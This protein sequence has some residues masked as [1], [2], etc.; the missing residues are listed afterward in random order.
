MKAGKFFFC[1]I[2]LLLAGAVFGQKKSLQEYLSNLPFPMPKTELPKFNNQYYYLT[3]FGGKNDGVSLNTEAFKKAIEACNQHGGGHVVVTNGVWLTGP[4][5]IKSNVDLHV[6]KGAIIL[7][8]RDH[9]QYPMINAGKGVRTLTTAFP[10]YS[11]HS[12]N[13][14]IT[15]SGSID[16]AGD[17]WRPVKKVKTTPAQ[18]DEF[19]RTGVISKDGKIWWPSYEAMNGEEYLAKFTDKKPD[20]S[21]Y[22]KARDYLRP[23]MVYFYDCKNV[24]LDS[25]TLKNSPMFMFYPN[26]CTNLYLHKVTVYNEWWAQNGDGIDIS[27]S[28]NVILYDCSV[29]AGDDGIC[30][31]SS[32]K[33]NNGPQLENILIL[34]CKVFKAHGGF[35]VG[36]NTD[37]GMRNIYVKDCIYDGTDVGINMKSN[38]GRGGLV[39]NIYIDNIV[40]KNIVKEAI[41][42]NAYYENVP[43]GKE[44]KDVKTTAT[45]KIP[46]FTNIHI[47]NIFCEGANTGVSITGLP[48]MPVHDIYFSNMSIIAK[49]EVDTTHV[50]NLNFENVRISK[51]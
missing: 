7:F 48:Y 38:S 23:H 8:T 46:E 43:A 39:E 15:G 14:A 19:T 40:M 3:D 17:S 18:W 49:K 21:E 35:S 33:N 45:D 20:S 22:L 42:F 30:M 2:L 50:K 51:K 31:K 27:A 32:G 10:I 13:I 24:F 29:N 6:D 4:I 37:G 1:S 47:S 11:I 28:K 25:I 34:A 9:T 16:G 41:L 26:N 5:E 36:S 12:E 44:A